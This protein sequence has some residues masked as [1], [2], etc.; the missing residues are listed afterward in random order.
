MHPD[1]SPFALAGGHIARIFLPSNN[2]GIFS[3]LTDLVGPTHEAAWAWMTFCDT[4][5]S[6]VLPALCH[7]LF[8]QIAVKSLL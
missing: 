1:E 5:I 7:P 4:K 2:N 8:L 3:A 6:K